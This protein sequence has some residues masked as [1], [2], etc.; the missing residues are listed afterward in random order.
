MQKFFEGGRK[1]RQSTVKEP[2]K[3]KKKRVMEPFAVSPMKNP[4]VDRTPLD[5]H[6]LIPPKKIKTINGIEDGIGNSKSKTRR[7][8]KQAKARRSIARRQQIEDG[9]TMVQ[10]SSD[11]MEETSSDEDARWKTRGES[12]GAEVKG[13]SDYQP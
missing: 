6:Q 7:E 1:A 11:N 3:S 9:G 4:N 10:S 5:A 12:S 2:T 13:D 8:R